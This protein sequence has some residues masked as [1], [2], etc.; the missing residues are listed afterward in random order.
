VGQILFDDS[1]KAYGRRPVAALKTSRVT[2]DLMIAEPED[3]L[4]R[5]ARYDELILQLPF[6]WHGTHFAAGG[7]GY[8]N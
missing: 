8:A 4:Y 1:S 3:D 6:S 7:S 2:H 5:F